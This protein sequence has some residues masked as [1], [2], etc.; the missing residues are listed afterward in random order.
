[1]AKKFELA[2]NRTCKPAWKGNKYINAT[3]RH[4]SSDFLTDDEAKMLLE[5]GHLTESDFTV[6]PE[7]NSDYTEEE[8]NCIVEFSEH[9]KNGK[10][11][12]EIIE[13]YKDIEKIGEK[14]CTKKLLKNLI[15]E[16]EK[17]L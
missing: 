8:L 14:K 3:A 9:L 6:L 7:A 10:K 13:L 2:K 15:A 17:S 16:A 11:E 12:A 5:K 1:M 4:W